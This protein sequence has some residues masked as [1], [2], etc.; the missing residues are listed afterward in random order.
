M[1]VIITNE[2]IMKLCILMIYFTINNYVCTLFKLF[3]LNI[4]YNY[5]IWIMFCSSCI[6][7]NDLFK[8]HILS[9]SLSFQHLIIYW[10]SLNSFILLCAIIVTRG[11]LEQLQQLDFEV[12]VFSSKYNFT[13]HFTSQLSK[14]NSIALQE[15]WQCSTLLYFFFFF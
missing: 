4:V 12:F 1:H 2:V 9:L 13:L 6:Q 10:L 15:K 8:F 14:N 11:F 7:L 3:I 5:L